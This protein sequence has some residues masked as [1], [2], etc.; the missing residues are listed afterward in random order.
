MKNRR[1]VFVGTIAFLILVLVSLLLRY[2]YIQDRSAFSY[3]S[4]Y[5]NNLHCLFEQPLTEDL[6][7]VAYRDENQCAYVK[8]VQKGVLN[9]Y[10]C[11]VTQGGYPL[12]DTGNRTEDSIEENDYLLIGADELSRDP[13][14]R[15]QGK[16]TDKMLLAWGIVYDNSVASVEIWGN[17]ANMIA[18]PGYSSRICYFV[19]DDYEEDFSFNYGES[20]TIIRR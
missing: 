4:A 6:I 7:L 11:G 20:V 14:N 16:E 15:H 18:L 12:I 19:T 3:I 9:D 5:D 13:G 2:Q 17:P 8:I 10:S 1:I